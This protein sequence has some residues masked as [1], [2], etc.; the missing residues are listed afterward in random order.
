LKERKI[1]ENNYSSPQDAESLELAVLGKLKGG[2]AEN[3]DDSGVASAEALRKTLDEAYSCNARQSSLDVDAG[4]CAPAVTPVSPAA[5]SSTGQASSR[6]KFS[7]SAEH[8][9][10]VVVVVGASPIII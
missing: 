4:I 5:T 7:G 1:G 6:L 10:H 9:T 8:T 2:N 3:A